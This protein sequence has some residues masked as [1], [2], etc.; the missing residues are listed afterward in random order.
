MMKI[1][2]PGKALLAG[3]ISSF[4][5]IAASTDVPVKNKQKND[6]QALANDWLSIG[7]DFRKAVKKVS[8][9]R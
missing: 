9:T 4:D 1:T 6:R 2:R 7:G 3:F 8:A 5:L